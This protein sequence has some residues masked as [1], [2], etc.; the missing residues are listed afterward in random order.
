MLDH[1]LILEPKD[2]DCLSVHSRS[3]S[4]DSRPTYAHASGVGAGDE[5]LDGNL[6]IGES[7]ANGFNYGAKA[8]RP[9]DRST[10]KPLVI[11][12]VGSDQGLNSLHIPR[13][14][15]VHDLS[16]KASHV[17]RGFRHSVNVHGDRHPVGLDDMSIRL[18]DLKL[19]GKPWFSRFA[20]S[21]KMRLEMKIR[22]RRLQL[23]LTRRLRYS[24]S[25]A[26]PL[27]SAD[28]RA[29]P[30]FLERYLCS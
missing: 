10:S 18:P 14:E 6:E 8:G 11:D 21:S 30:R 16:G 12:I 15:Q 7:S 29:S 4:L 3:V 28:D 19:T 25:C 22:S 13:G 23:A 2:V 5:V 1:P 26:G 9:I 27:P 20:M 24:P 17:R